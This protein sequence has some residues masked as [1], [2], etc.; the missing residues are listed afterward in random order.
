MGTCSHPATSR[1]LWR[2]P[3]FLAVLFSSNHGLLAWTPIL[4]FAV[5]GLVLFRWREPRAGAPLL[6]A[7]LAFYLFIA[8]Y[9]DW[10]GISS[11]GNRF[12]VSLTALFI[13]G[14]AVFLDRA[15]QLFRSQRAAFAAASA[16][17]ALFVLWNVGLMFQ[18]G[19]H[20]VPARGPVSFSE[21]IHNQFFVVPRQL[22]ADLRTYLF[23]RKALMQQIEDRDLRQL[24]KNSSQP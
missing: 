22:A 8:C 21:V 4:I 20:L 18:W 16:L 9:P 15:A 11:F 10:A 23:N 19:S 24:E 14:L 12:F 17:L 5:A 1:W 2:S 3:A 7:F 6:A 13:L